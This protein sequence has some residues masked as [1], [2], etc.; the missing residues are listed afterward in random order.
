[1]SSNLFQNKLTSKLFACNFYKQ[2]LA[3]YNSLEGWYATKHQLAIFI[4]NEKDRW[5]M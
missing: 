4:T 3:L 2:D 5:F 1:M